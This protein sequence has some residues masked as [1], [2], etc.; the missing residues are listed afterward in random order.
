MTTC[1]MDDRAAYNKYEPFPKYAYECIKYL[2]NNNEL[3]WRL[4]KYNT[5]TAW[6]DTDLTQPDLTQEEKGALIW[7]GYGDSSDF[8]VFMDDGVPDVE[9]KEITRLNIFPYGI[10]PRDRT[11]GSVTLMMEVYSHFKINTLSNYETR[12]DRIIQQLLYTFNGVEIP[13]LGISK[14][15]F[16]KRGL[17]ANRLE[18]AGQLPFRGKWLLFGSH[19]V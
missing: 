16:D 3:I 19:T 9:T 10:S 15:F 14:I 2:M 5:P 13:N 4:L 8:R 18:V 6:D 11:V 12:V 7:S 17:G 1:A